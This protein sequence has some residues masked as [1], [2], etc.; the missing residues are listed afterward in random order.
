MLILNT[1][2]LDEALLTRVVCEVEVSEILAVLP[3][4]VLTFTMFGA[5]I[6]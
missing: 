4:M 5:A 6:F 2:P 1:L 3:I